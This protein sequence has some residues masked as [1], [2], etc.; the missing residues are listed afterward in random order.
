MER[1][2]APLILT[3]AVGA[4]VLG[5]CGRTVAGVL[6]RPFRL[7]AYFEEEF[8]DGLCGHGLEQ[9]PINYDTH[10]VALI[11]RNRL[12][13]FNRYSSVQVSVT[14]TG[15]GV[16]VIMNSNPGSV[17]VN[18]KIYNLIQ[19]HFHERSEETINGK[20]KTAGVHMVHI[21]VDGDLLVIGLLLQAGGVPNRVLQNILDNLNGTTWMNPSDLL[22]PNP[23]SYFHNRGSLT[24]PPCSEGV[25][26]Y[27]M[28]Q[29]QS[30]SDAQAE[31]LNSIYAG[32]YRPIQPLNQR[33]LFGTAD[34]VSRQENS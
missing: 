20:Y 32:N 16:K 18:G 10:A 28:S 8:K 2:I 26:W 29:I 33:T 12:L 27:I 21:D 24:T 1:S 19:F 7:R 31:Q 15:K 3:F 17:T 5:G 25:L 14:N 22:P 9:S 23:R 6:Q 34:L 13:T 30:I 11:E 4:F